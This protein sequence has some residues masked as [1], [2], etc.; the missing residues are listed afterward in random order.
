MRQRSLVIG[1]RAG[2]APSQYNRRMVRL[3]PDRTKLRLGRSQLVGI[4]C[5]KMATVF[6]D[7]PILERTPNVKADPCFCVFLHGDVLGFS[8]GRTPRDPAGA[9]CLF[10]R[11]FA[12][13]PKTTGRRWGSPT[14][15]AAEPAKTEFCLSKGIPEPRPV[16]GFVAEKYVISRHC[17]RSEA[18]QRAYR[19]DCFV[20]EPVIGRAFARPVGSSQ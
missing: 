20:A 10:A 17:E 16:G 8:P 6:R 13:L 7:R 19:M 15:L 2:I 9:A 11:R 18:I 12:L 4:A 3:A 14:M 5:S 1:H